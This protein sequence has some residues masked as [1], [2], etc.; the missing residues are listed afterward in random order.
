[1]KVNA[2]ELISDLT[3]RVQD[4]IIEV[5]NFKILPPEELNRRTSPNSW[6]ILECIE[7][8][9]LYGDYYLPE[10]EKRIKNNNTTPD[11]LFESGVIGDYFAK[12]MLPREKLNKMKT[13]R[14]KNPL[15]SKLDKQVLQR[16]L[17]QQKKMLELLKASKGVSLNR[18]KT[19]LSLTRFLKLKL[20]DT[21]RVVIYHNER[22]IQQAK[23]VQI[24]GQKVQS[25]A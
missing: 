20:G 22:H 18:T 6:S 16:F 15:G 21:F 13:F 23:K 3:R 19:S 12:M 9:N 24:S 17:D 7:H 10:I 5:E 1:M 25:P 11:P 4:Q 14:D 2:E 8:L